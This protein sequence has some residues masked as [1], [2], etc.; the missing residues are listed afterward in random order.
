MKTKKEKILKSIIIGV[1]VIASAITISDDIQYRFGA[2]DY[3][4]ADYVDYSSN[5]EDCNVAGIE[6]HGDLWT[7][8]V[9]SQDQELDIVA[10]ENVVSAINEAER[11]ENIKAIILEIDSYGG[12]PVAGEEVANALRRADVITVALIRGAGLSAAYWAGTGADVIIASENSDVGSIGVTMSYLDNARSNQTEGLTYNQLSFGK[13]KD[14]G[15]PNKTLT[16]E[17]KQYLM[18]DVNIIAENFIKEVSENRSLAI[19]K[20]RALADGSSMLGAMALEN[21]LIDKIGDLQT[22]KEYLEDQLGE[23]VEVCWFE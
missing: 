22:T 9:I 10:S 13:Y 3:Y 21:G 18:R 17:E 8:E 1:V 14:A 12:S 11:D 19:E 23:S 5:T 15:D 4:D 7:Y 6:L 20:V 2:D 16:Y